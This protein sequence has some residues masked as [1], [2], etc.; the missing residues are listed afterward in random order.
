MSGPTRG[1]V[2]NTE[3]TPARA[4][5]PRRAAPSAHSSTS[6][7]NQA[8][9]LAIGGNWGGQTLGNTQPNK[10][11]TSSGVYTL[12][13]LGQADGAG[14]P[15]FVGGFEIV[16]GNGTGT[17]TQNSGTNAIVG[18][19]KSNAAGQG[20]PSVYNNA[21]GAL[22]L[23]WTSGYQAS[24]SYIGSPPL[25][26]AGYYGNAVGTYNLNG[27]IL[28]G[29]YTTN[30]V[31]GEECVGIGGTGIFNQSG[32][33][34]VA[35]TGLYVG[36]AQMPGLMPNGGKTPNGV[37][38]GYGQYSLSA[39]LLQIPDPIRGEYIG[40]GTKG[41]FTQT[42]GTNQTV[43][44][45]LGSANPM[46]G[47]TGNG[48]SGSGWHNFFWTS[49]VYNL[50]GGV[51]ETY[52]IGTHNSISSFNFTGGTLQA[53]AGEV[54]VGG[55]NGLTI[56]GT[57]TVGTAASDVATVDAHGQ[58]AT[59]DSSTGYLTGP[60]QL[61]VIC[62]AAGGTVVLGGNDFFSG[63]AFVNNYTGGTT[64]LSGT[65]QVLNY[66]ALP[67]LGVLTVG[68]PVSVTM[69]APAGTLFGSNADLRA[70]C[71]PASTIG[72]IGLTPSEV[73]G[74][75]LAAPVAPSATG[76]GVG[77]VPL[78]SRPAPVPEPST[79]ALLGAGLLS[80][81]AVCPAAIEDQLRPATKDRT[82]DESPFGFFLSEGVTY[83]RRRAREQFASLPYLF[84]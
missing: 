31:G 61:R 10:C 65:L 71:P 62:G 69:N 64:V 50:A 63:A 12:G 35:N 53:A 20:S 78:G 24:T 30:S 28:T 47:W 4:C 48:T 73:T 34:N 68:G 82:R 16:G 26:G 55:S 15:L 13:T 66:Q 43:G 18:G 41:V 29:S 70:S 57:I 8:V 72:S 38:G 2:N 42:G 59:L 37:W 52:S 23:G 11:T 54:A 56:S 46:T 25:G 75:A 79:L 5:S 60:G 40:S 17:F 6:G 81:L 19:G 45:G 49:G 33:T 39:G 44:V 76:G 32:G 83:S 14:G 7:S 36:V 27:G 67:T 84:F 3:C 21:N 77:M 22:I 1:K 51:L 9:G 80:L 74:E 58:T